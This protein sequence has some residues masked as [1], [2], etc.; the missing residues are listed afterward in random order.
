LIPLTPPLFF[1]FTQ[2]LSANKTPKNFVLKKQ[3]WY[4]K[5]Q[6]FIHADFKTAEKIAK[7][8]RTKSY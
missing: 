2:P 4:Q 1:H 7:K 8:S 3:E 6:N 5:P